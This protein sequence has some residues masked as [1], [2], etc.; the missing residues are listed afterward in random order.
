MIRRPPRSTLHNTL[1]PYTTLFRSIAGALSVGIG[2][3]LNQIASNFI[4][5]LIMLIEIG[6]AHV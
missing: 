6:R 4:S 3:G 1:F 2:F 5:G